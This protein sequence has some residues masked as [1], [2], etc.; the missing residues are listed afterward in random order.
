MSNREWKR[1]WRSVALYAAVIAVCVVL[2]FPIYWMFNTSLGPRDELFVYPPRL[3]HP[4]I[5]FD[6]YIKVWTERP[7]LRWLTNSGFIVLVSVSFS[8][9]MSICAGY[10]LS[11]YRITGRMIIHEF[12]LGTRMLPTTLLIIPLFVLVKKAGLIN[13]LYSV[14]IADMIFIVP[15]ATLMLRGYFDSI[16][17]ELEEAA[18]IDG[19]SRLG[20]VLRITLPLARPGIMAAA[21]FAIIM[22]WDEYMFA[23]TFITSANKWTITMGLAGFKGEYV[24]W[25][26]E[27]MAA[28]L[29][30]TLPIAVIFMVSARYL[31][32]GLTA[33]YGK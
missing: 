32:S 31:V 13:S 24:T 26:N 5:Q 19:C 16:P 28:S 15:L 1:V 27:V 18:M 25:W 30:G 11:R 6:S 7:M 23:R 20:A 29:I 22:A 8:L 33:G 9:A 14:V 12:L 17:R 10:S 4:H 21:V 3:I 2:D